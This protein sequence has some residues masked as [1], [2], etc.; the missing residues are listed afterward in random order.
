MSPWKLAAGYAAVAAAI[1]GVGAHF[2]H[3]ALQIPLEAR[4]VVVA[5]DE[6]F[7]TPLQLQL[8]LERLA[9]DSALY[10]QGQSDRA[11][12][13]ERLEVVKSKAGILK[14]ASGSGSPVSSMSEYREV[15]TQ[16]PGFL[17]HAHDEIVE[18]SPNSLRQLRQAIDE[19]R[20]NLTSLS[21]SARAAGLAAQT[22]REMELERKRSVVLL[23]L[24]FGWLVLCGL[25]L[26]QLLSMRRVLM[27]LGVA[28]DEVAQQKR[29]LEVA[30]KTEAARNTFM[31]KVS[32][33]IN[34]PL[35]AI[36]TNV[37]LMEGRLD[38]RESLAKIVPRLKASVTHLR[39]QVHD[40]LDVAEV[41]SG[42]LAVKFGE[43]DIELLV[44]ECIS[45][46]QTAAEN[47]GLNLT[48]NTS[49]LQPIRSDGRRLNQILTNLVTNAIRYTEVGAIHV[50]ASIEMRNRDQATLRLVVRDSGIGF[51][52]EVL[53][54][55]YQAFMQV[56]KHRG[57]S[58][59]G[60]AIVKGLVDQLN[61]S[62]DLKTE[63]NQG[64]QF[65][66][67]MPVTVIPTGA[68]TTVP[69]AP[70]GQPT[71][72]PET[73]VLEFPAEVADRNTGAA[74][75]LLFVEDDPDI[76]DTMSELL[77]HLGYVCHPA[78]SMQEGLNRLTERK[79]AAIVV[80]MELGDGTGLDVARASKSTVNRSVPLIVCTAYSDLLDQPGM[81]I[82]DARFRKPVDANALRDMLSKLVGEREAATQ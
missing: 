28:E 53:E 61:G 75:H 55:L 35:Q 69:V 38:N 54:N 27:R 72:L 43:V 36:L 4:A 10:A 64:S 9:E 46:Q 65:T 39:G 1:T 71:L 60:L 62:I 29:L 11:G 20:G 77:E 16:L 37:Q 45:V 22:T 17:Q 15:M 63:V 3:D 23:S 32:H 80:D 24:A 74:R 19:L 40:L 78:S 66:I 70:A 58:G 8:A 76:Q 59:L 41:N 79:Y 30:A 13:Q 51:A 18:A 34:S 7:W 2:V 73:S 12:M 33:E 67:T 47:K 81:D 44:E 26:Q 6:I 52:P 50:E 68:R 5:R 31:G 48:L 57:G 42:K 14:G 21:V 25:G 82:F 56:V 49:N